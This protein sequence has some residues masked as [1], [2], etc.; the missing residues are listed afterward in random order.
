[1]HFDEASNRITAIARAHQRLYQT[2]MFEKIELGPYIE[3]ICQTFSESLPD[4]L[5][6][7]SISSGIEVSPDQAIP[8]A[9]FVSEL[10]TNSAK[11]GH[12][13]GKCEIWIEIVRANAKISVSVRDEGIG[14]PATFTASSR[15]GLGMQLVKAFAE[16]LGGLLEIRRHAPGVEFV[17][18]FPTRPITGCRAV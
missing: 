12:A 10:I 8:V 3:D 18:T 11:Y 17:L 1:M 5:L 9:L 4:C 2:E 6:H 14:L 13:N 15:K 7:V 16:Q